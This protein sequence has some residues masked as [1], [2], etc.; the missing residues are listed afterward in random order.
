[1]DIPLNMKLF[2]GSAAPPTAPMKAEQ[3]V[4]PSIE[5]DG[6][7]ID[8]TCSSD[9]EAEAE[10]EVEAKIEDDTGAGAESSAQTTTSPCIRRMD[11]LENTIWRKCCRQVLA[12]HIGTSRGA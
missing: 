11:T 5:I 8:S 4:V 1:M 6:T 10:A 2:A 3:S 12:A 9:S 7:F